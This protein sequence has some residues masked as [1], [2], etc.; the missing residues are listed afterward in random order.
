MAV[1]K[2]MQNK[3]LHKTTH[4]E[5]HTNNIK[6]KVTIKKRFTFTKKLEKIRDS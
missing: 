6:K 5:S 2:R 3:Y 1:V 4:S